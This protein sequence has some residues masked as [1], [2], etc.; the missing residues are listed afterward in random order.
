MLTASSTIK[1][2]LRFG[3]VYGLLQDA[4]AVTMGRPL[5]YVDGLKKISSKLHGSRDDEGE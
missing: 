1:T 2:G 5:W 4:I 3:L